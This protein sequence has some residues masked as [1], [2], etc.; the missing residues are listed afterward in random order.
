MREKGIEAE[1]GMDGK[2]FL[3]TH[4]ASSSCAF[5]GC[6]L[7]CCML[8][9]EEF[10]QTSIKYLFGW[11]EKAAAADFAIISLCTLTSGHLGKLVVV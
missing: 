6:F 9:Y 5:A 11:E 1:I 4:R 3:Q 7:F 8:G 2:N 10:A